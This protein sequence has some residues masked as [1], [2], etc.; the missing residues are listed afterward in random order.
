[1][2]ISRFYVKITK[3]DISF[4]LLIIHH[5]NMFSIALIFKNDIHLTNFT[6]S[7]CFS[8]HST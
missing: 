3:K 8:Y 7:T 6:I 5:K 2:I 1:M 4:N